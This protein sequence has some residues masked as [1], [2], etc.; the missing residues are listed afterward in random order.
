M[1]KAIPTAQAVAVHATDAAE[2][3]VQTAVN[4]LFEQR[5]REIQQRKDEVEAGLA[6]VCAYDM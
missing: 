5:N 4:S 6:R 3:Q 2:A 1:E